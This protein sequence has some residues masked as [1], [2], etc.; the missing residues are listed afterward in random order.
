MTISWR[1]QTAQECV[2]GI[3]RDIAEWGKA[4]KYPNEGVE[5][6]PPEDQFQDLEDASVARLMRRPFC[7]TEAD[8]RKA[9]KAE[10]DLI[11]AASNRFRQRTRLPVKVEITKEWCMA[12]AKLEGDSD[13]EI[14]AGHL[15]D[16]STDLNP[17]PGTE[18]AHYEWYEARFHSPIEMPWRSYE[19]T[20][21]EHAAEQY[22]HDERDGVFEKSGDNAE[23]T[24]R[25]RSNP[26]Y[27]QLLEVESTI[28][29]VYNAA[30]ID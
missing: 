17:D 30:R 10:V 25:K 1:S 21:F 11:R 14:G 24:V 22:A 23:V 2:E 6:N 9:A 12:M 3:R 16:P 26:G 29:P 7:M 4:Q 28:E 20:S 27:V 19:A 15:V 13:S 8:A 5:V 18:I